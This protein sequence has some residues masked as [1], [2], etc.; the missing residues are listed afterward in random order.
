MRE[1]GAVEHQLIIWYGFGVMNAGVWD[2]K[3]VPGHSIV[4]NEGTQ[5]FDFIENRALGNSS[6]LMKSIATLLVNQGFI[7][8]TVI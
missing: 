5:G 1:D 4:A 2:G 3:R 7:S 8:G 6:N